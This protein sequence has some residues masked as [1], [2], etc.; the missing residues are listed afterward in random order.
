[1]NAAF[2]A[3]A[4]QGSLSRL[5]EIHLLLSMSEAHFSK[6]VFMRK[7][8]LNLIFQEIQFKS[9]LWERSLELHIASELVHLI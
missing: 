3:L 9:A 4:A 2:S 6:L 7:S 1:V 5:Q 8:H